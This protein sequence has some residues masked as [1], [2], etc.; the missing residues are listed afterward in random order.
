[1]CP[2]HAEVDHRPGGLGHTDV[3]VKPIHGQCYAVMLVISGN[4]NTFVLDAAKVFVF[5]IAMPTLATR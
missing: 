2:I 1:M 3:P 5:F 4:F